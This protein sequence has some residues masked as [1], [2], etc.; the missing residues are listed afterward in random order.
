M[1][2]D[3]DIM[4]QDILAFM[5]RFGSLT[6]D[7]AAGTIVYEAFNKLALQLFRYQFQYNAPY[8]KYCQARRKSPLN[9]RR[10]DEIPP[11]PVLAF[12]ELTLSCEPPDEAEALFMTSGTTHA[13]MRGCNYHPTLRVWDR[14]MALSFKAYVLPDTEK[15]T[16]LAISPGSDQNPNSSLSRYMSQAV[17]LYGK[18]DSRFFH[19]AGSGLDMEALASALQAVRGC[20]EPILIMG[21]TFSYVHFLDYCRDR[22]LAFVLPANSVLF[23][24]GGLKGQAREVSAHELYR[25]FSSIFGVGCS[26]FVNMYGMTELSTQLYDRTL[27]HRNP[28]ADGQFYQK[29]SGPAWV[30]TLV[31]DPGTLEPVGEGNSGILAHF[32][33]ANWNAV[34][35]VLTEDLGVMTGNGL[36]LEGRLQGSEARGCSVAADQLLQADRHE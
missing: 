19:H 10:W 35:A 28:D 3:S 31:L 4:V 6:A 14:S 7:E 33:L 22:G 27:L 15:M 1:I 30:R 23:D 12:K 21:T 13:D 5:E 11:L 29:K 17:K 16:I 25:D 18:S 34:M 9:V 26:R 8:R 32:D 2:A 24:T 36:V 20:D